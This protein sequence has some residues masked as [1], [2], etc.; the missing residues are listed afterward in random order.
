MDA[1]QKASL[2]QRLEMINSYGIDVNAHEEQFEEYLFLLK[3]ICNVPVTYVSVLDDKNQHIL[4]HLNLNYDCMPNKQSFCQHTIK[5]QGILIIEDTLSDDRFKDLPLV[6][7]EN[8]RFYAGYPL[9]TDGNFTMGALCVMDNVP[10]SLNADQIKG[11]RIIANKVVAAINA[12]KKAL[13]F[14]SEVREEWHVDI[15]KKINGL[16]EKLLEKTETLLDKNKTIYE[17]NLQLKETNLKNSQ[18]KHQLALVTDASPSCIL[19]I[20]TD[21]EYVLVNKTFENWFGKPRRS[22]IGLHLKKHIG[23]KNFDKEKVNL[24]RAFNGEQFHCERDVSFDMDNVNPIR[25]KINY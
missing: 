1:R 15:S 17:Q 13:G 2:N 23:T 22:L 24:D 25:V 9:I 10:G 6:E 21:Y 18:S 14:F 4:N 12:R 11:F 5:Q 19:L 7:A 20:N 8:I 3:T 16:Q